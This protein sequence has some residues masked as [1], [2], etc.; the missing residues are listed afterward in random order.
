MPVDREQPVS[1]AKQTPAIFHPRA[2]RRR[3]R[4][5]ARVMEG[6]EDREL[7]AAT[8][9]LGEAE[10]LGEGN[11]VVRRAVS[12]QQPPGETWNRGER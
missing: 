5:R 1:E 10:A 6:V 11:R 8:R 3:H 7:R 9:S 12:D 2:Q 4:L